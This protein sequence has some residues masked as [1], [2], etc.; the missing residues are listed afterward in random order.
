M[1]SSMKGVSLVNKKLSNVSFRIDTDIKNQADMPRFL[2]SVRLALHPAQAINQRFL[3]FSFK[4]F[5]AIIMPLL[6]S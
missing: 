4:V 1:D 3:S 6:P 5:P 2:R